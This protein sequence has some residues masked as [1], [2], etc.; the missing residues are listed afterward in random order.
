LTL[1][2]EQSHA[3]GQQIEHGLGPKLLL[4]ILFQVML[5]LPQTAPHSQPLAYFPTGRANSFI[6]CCEHNIRKDLMKDCRTF[7]A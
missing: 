4:A 1:S 2:I 3:N 6:V 5:R 7:D